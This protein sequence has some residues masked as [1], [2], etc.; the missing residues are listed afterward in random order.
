M[1]QLSTIHYIVIFIVISIAAFF[2]FNSYIYHQK[3][4]SSQSTDP[5]TGSLTVT[6]SCLSQTN[7]DKPEPAGCAIGLVTEAGENYV[8]DF[9]KMP[10]LRTSLNLGDRF[11]A[12]G[13]IT[14]IENISSNMWQNYD[15]E[16]IFTVTDSLQIL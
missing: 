1:K 10:Q 8:L 6:Y 16:G 15:V 11:T 4:A 9:N 2:A 5:Y 12:T 13:T 14:P 7:Q 3:Q